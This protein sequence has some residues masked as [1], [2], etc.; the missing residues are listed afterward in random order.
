MA[1]RKLNYFLLILLIIAYWCKLINLY[2]PLY[3]LFTAELVSF[4]I[5]P[6]CDCK[7]PVSPLELILNAVLALGTDFVFSEKKNQ[8]NI[9][10]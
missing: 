10:N 5:D 4:I 2:L 7:V 1:Q 9:M 6:L 3:V 8:W